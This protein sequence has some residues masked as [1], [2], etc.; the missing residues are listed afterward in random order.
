MPLLVG[1]GGDRVT[2][3]LVARYADANNVGG[4]FENVRRKDAILRE[5]CEAVGRD[6]RE[7]ERTTGIGALFIRDSAAEA[8]RVQRATFEHNGGAAPWTANQ[9]V[10]TPERVVE[11]LEPYLGIGNHHFIAGFPSP[12][13][14][15]SMARF[16]AEV[17]PRL[18]AA[19]AV[20]APAA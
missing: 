9:P 20:R 11:L 12:Y 3:R 7:I 18:E 14:R 13:D 16:V 19:A 15:E 6:D 5:H 10:G 4:G 17:K 8:K 2:L 1:G